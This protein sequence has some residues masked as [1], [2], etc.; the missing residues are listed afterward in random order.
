MTSQALDKHLREYVSRTAEIWRTY[1]STPISSFFYNFGIHIITILLFFVLIVVLAVHPSKNSILLALAELVFIIAIISFSLLTVL[2]T[3]E[4]TYRF[5][6]L[7]HGQH[8][9]KKTQSELRLIENRDIDGAK[10]PFYD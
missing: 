4:T 1:H 8:I 9:Q 3:L 5:F 10:V 7:S 6:I 2:S